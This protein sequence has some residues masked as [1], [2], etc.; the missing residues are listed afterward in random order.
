ME[1]V[2]LPAVEQLRLRVGQSARPGGDADDGR[3]PRHPVAVV[4]QHRDHVR[5][6]RI[7]DQPGLRG[8]FAHR[9]G[10][11]VLRAGGLATGQLEHA[12]QRAAQQ[13]PARVV[14]DDG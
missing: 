3:E 2:E 5:V 12:V 9:G 1:V 7:G 4:D 6:G 10:G 8:E 14:G 11:E 13:D